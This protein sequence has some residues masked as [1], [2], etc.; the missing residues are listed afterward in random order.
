MT[1]RFSSSFQ[2]DPRESW[3]EKHNREVRDVWAAFEADRP[4]RV[5]VVFSGVRTASQQTVG[6]ATLGGFVAAGGLGP[7]VFLGLAQ[8]ANDL[9]LLGSLAIVV[10]ALTVDGLMR[11]VQH[12]ISPRHVRK[13]AR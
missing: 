4:I 8:Q 11:G 6:N 5:P 3:V 9:V 1:Y 13:A 10:L 12:L 7:L 2:I